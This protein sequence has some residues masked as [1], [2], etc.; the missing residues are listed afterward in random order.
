M[1]SD[2]PTGDPTAMPTPWFAVRRRIAQEWGIAPWE[3][4]APELADEV[5]RLLEYASLEAQYAPPAGQ[6]GRRDED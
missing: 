6:P 4:D 5:G 1:P 2:R 3:V